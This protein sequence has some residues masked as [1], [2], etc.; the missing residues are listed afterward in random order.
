[1]RHRAPMPIL[2][3]KTKTSPASAAT[4]SPSCPT[5]SG[6]NGA[7]YGTKSNRCRNV[8]RRRSSRRPM[9]ISGDPAGAAVCQGVCGPLAARVPPNGRRPRLGAWWRFRPDSA[10]PRQSVLGISPLA[11][12][13][14]SWR[15]L[16]GAA[17]SGPRG[18]WH[19][20]CVSA[21]P[22]KKLDNRRT[23]SMIPL[24]RPPMT[25]ESVRGLI[26]RRGFAPL[27]RSGRTSTWAASEGGG[28]RRS[29]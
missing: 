16:G 2:G 25:P 24:Q 15:D 21:P 6:T 29:H 5:P 19:K 26:A 28:A 4:P 7:S 20:P 8:R 1:M 14:Q 27:A 17:R 3:S 10:C 23:V 22:W 13:A 18:R 11:K 9:A 12:R